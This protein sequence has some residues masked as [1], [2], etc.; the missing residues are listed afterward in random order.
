M[1]GLGIFVVYSPC[2]DHKIISL[3]H[4]ILA[5]QFSLIQ[6]T[7]F[8]TLRPATVDVVIS[9]EDHLW[10][11]NVPTSYKLVAVIVDFGS[12]ITVKKKLG[13]C[14]PVYERVVDED[15]IVVS[16]EED[17]LMED[18]VGIKSKERPSR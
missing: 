11:D 6:R 9:D 10:Q 18:Q 16:D 7:Q 13:V 12:G 4:L 15:A 8:K 2:L 3:D 1:E 17:A 5:F 14:R